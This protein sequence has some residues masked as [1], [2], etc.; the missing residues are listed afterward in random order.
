MRGLTDSPNQGKYRSVK[1]CVD[2][3]LIYV[4]ELIPD[5]NLLG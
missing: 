1:I 3:H 2:M 5:H 4:L